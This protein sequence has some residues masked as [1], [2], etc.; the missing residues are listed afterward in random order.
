[1]LIL[2]AIA[3]SASE[4]NGEYY[5]NSDHNFNIIFP[6]EWVL[7]SDKSEHAIVEAYYSQNSI[8]IYQEVL[9]Y[10]FNVRDLT[11]EGK[12]EIISSFRSYYSENKAFKEIEF[13]INTGKNIIEIFGEYNNLEY[14]SR[15]F[16]NK[17][18]VFIIDAYYSKPNSKLKSDIFKSINSFK[19]GRKNK[20]NF[21]AT[22]KEIY[23]RNKSSDSNL[24]FGWILGMICIGIIIMIIST[25]KKDDNKSVIKSKPIVNK[26]SQEII[27]K[28]KKNIKDIKFETYY[29]IL[30]LKN[31]ASIEEV[32]NKKTNLLLF[33]TEKELEDSKYG[34]PL[35]VL[36]NKNL[37]KYYDSYIVSSS[38]NKEFEEKHLNN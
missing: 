7:N 32:R 26:A 27:P 25:E 14:Y 12:K 28:R 17:E 11:E 22:K 23:E 38:G 24:S 3:F 4:Y 34:T 35:K 29:N 13:K 30:L 37:K 10:D 33:F 15:I 5:Y 21:E 31:D 36:N 9:G 6:P 20:K 18:E 19:F 2:S 16:P 1:V 8:Y